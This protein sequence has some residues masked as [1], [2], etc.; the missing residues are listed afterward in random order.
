MD[1]IDDFSNI[2]IT[3]I[4]PMSKLEQSIRIDRKTN[5]DNSGW[6]QDGHFKIIKLNDWTGEGKAF[7]WGL[8]W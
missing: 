4:G 2:L 5:Y 1:Q 8:M 6:I 7:E 3:V